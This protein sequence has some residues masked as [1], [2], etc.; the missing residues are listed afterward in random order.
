MKR[1]SAPVMALVLVPVL[2]LTG[3]IEPPA[4]IRPQAASAAG[5]GSEPGTEK[6]PVIVQHNLSQVADAKAV[7]PAMLATIKVGETT[8]AQL[9]ELLGEIK[10]FTLGDGKKI[11]RYD[12]G[13][14]IF[15]AD[16]LLLRQHINH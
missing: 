15:G 3:C 14:F 10:P 13:K 7:T 8:T 16:G 6:A 4:N 11:Y 2:A 1:F 5:S 9:T 12:V